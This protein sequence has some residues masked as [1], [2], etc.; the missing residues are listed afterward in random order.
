MLCLASFK[1]AEK[2]S[3]LIQI[4]Q[5]SRYFARRPKFI[6][7]AGQ[8]HEREFVVVFSWQSV[9]S[10]QSFSSAMARLIRTAVSVLLERTVTLTDNSSATLRQCLRIRLRVPY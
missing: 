7:Y 8:Q 3:S 9:T 4:G 6:L 10:L 5:N 2:K 1:T